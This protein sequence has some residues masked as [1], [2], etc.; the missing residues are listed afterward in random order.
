MSIGDSR[1]LPVIYFGKLRPCRA[2]K[3]MLV[4]ARLRAKQRAVLHH[5]ANLGTQGL[6][7]VRAGYPG[8]SIRILPSLGIVKTQ[9]QDLRL[10]T[11]RSPEGADQHC[12]LAW[13]HL[14][15][16]DIPGVATRCFFRIQKTRPQKRMC[17]AKR[18]RRVSEST[19]SWISRGVA[20]S[21]R[22]RSPGC[23][24]P[25]QFAPGILPVGGWVFGSRFAGSWQK[26]IKS[27]GVEVGPRANIVERP[28]Q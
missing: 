13:L 5:N 23:E 10:W 26:T 8:P 28:N 11:C 20:R 22:I 9:Q 17:P 7:R 14:R 27:P 24:G 21:S 19:P 4:P 1:R 2:R 6:Y 16:L 25:A 12:F 3:A 18:R 15:K